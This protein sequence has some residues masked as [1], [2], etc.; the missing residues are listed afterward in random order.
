[1]P[2]SVLKE[3]ILSSRYLTAKQKQN[4]TKINGL[5][6]KSNLFLVLNGMYV[7]RGVAEN[8]ENISNE[9]YHWTEI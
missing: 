6:C 9:R 4:K 5:Y 3:F 1:M 8:I 2:K 7:A